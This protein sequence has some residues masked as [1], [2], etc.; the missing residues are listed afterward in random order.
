MLGFDIGEWTVRVLEEG[1]PAL[2]RRMDAS[3]TVPVAVWRGDRHGA[4][5][6]VR[7]WR[8]G[9]FD[10][11]CAIS[12][13]GADGSWEQPMVWGGGPWLDEPLVRSQSGW[14]GW[15]AVWLGTTG[16]DDVL[17]VRGAASARVAAIR[18]EQAGRVSLLPVDSP[19]GA[20]VVGVYAGA[21]PAT[22][23]PVGPDA[24]VLVGEDGQ[25]AAI[26]TGLGAP[27]EHERPQRGAWER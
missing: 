27:L 14:E 10:S 19:C 15:P 1:L 9:R 25:S 6:F 5:L 4:V 2:P 11:D 26:V 7:L 17:A 13:R 8:N 24:E 23:E 20:V 3:Q 18:V 22:L 12:E 16:A 21:G